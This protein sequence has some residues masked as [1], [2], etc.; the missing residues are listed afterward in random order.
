[1]KTWIQAARLRTLPLAASGIIVGSALAWYAD[2]FSWS[3]S[4]LALLTALLLQILSNFANDYGDFTK[5]TDNDD[6]VGP[7]R[8]MQSGAITAPQMKGA[9]AVTAL[10]AFG[11]GVLLIYKAAS[12]LGS[13]V[14]LFFGVLGML[15]IAAAI[16]YTVG[17]RAYGYFGMGD[18]MVFVF[19]GLASVVGTY[20]LNA[21]QLPKEIW[22]LA[23]AVGALSTGVLNLNNMRDIDNDMVS[24][25]NTLAARLGFKKA[26]IYHEILI[27]VGIIGFLG[28]TFPLGMKF[29][30][31]A[32]LYIPAAKLLSDLRKIK[33]TTDKARLDPFLKQLSL[34]TFFMSIAFVI[35]LVLSH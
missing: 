22:I 18:V 17:K 21:A 19:F 33:K 30:P 15:A 1:M 23:V 3:I 16:L 8:T 28:L 27:G 20:Y 29:W 35:A 24:G 10:M 25:K 2:A 26:K 6:R 4:A 7:Q 9:M 12:T 5:G 34:G 32:I 14:W 11:S 31:Y 13:I